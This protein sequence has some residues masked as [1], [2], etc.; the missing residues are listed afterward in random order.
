MNNDETENLNVDS[1]LSEIS[2]TMETNAEVQEIVA[3]AMRTAFKLGS[4]TKHPQ[5]QRI[6]DMLRIADWASQCIMTTVLDK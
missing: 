1:V 2:K 5:E 4:M 6:R 3:L